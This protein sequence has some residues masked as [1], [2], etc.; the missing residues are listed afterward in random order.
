[1]FNFI[2]KNCHLVFSKDLYKFTIL[3]TMFKTIIWCISSLISF[4]LSLFNL[5]HSSEYKNYYIVV[6][7]YISLFTN[8]VE[9]WVVNGHT[10][11]Y[12]LFSISYIFSIVNSLA[13]SFVP[14]YRTVFLFLRNLCYLYILKTK[15]FVKYIFGKISIQFIAC[16]FI[17]LM[18]TF[19]ENEF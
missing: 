14:F 6:F 9:K 10:Y 17:I 7:I 18:V 3:V 1:M 13:K 8:N 4:L 16:L 15:L 2:K 12:F 5:R 11:F 19:E